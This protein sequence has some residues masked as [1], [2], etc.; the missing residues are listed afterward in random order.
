M[1]GRHSERRVVQF[2]PGIVITE[3]Q[4]NMDETDARLISVDDRMC[5]FARCFELLE[6]ALYCRY[7][8]FESGGVFCLTACSSGRLVCEA[9][10]CESAPVCRRVIAA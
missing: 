8:V 7:L 6:A 3:R 1:I 4:H 9:L 5:N 10:P 2:Q